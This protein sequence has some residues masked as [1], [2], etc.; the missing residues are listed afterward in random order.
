MSHNL[1]DWSIQCHNFT[2]IS[3]YTVIKKHR[4]NYFICNKINIEL[5]KQS[6]KS[7]MCCSVSDITSQ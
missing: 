7:E 2:Q 3:M 1:T 5:Y 6:R 4:T